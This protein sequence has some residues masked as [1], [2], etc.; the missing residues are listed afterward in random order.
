MYSREESKRVREEFWTE[1]GKQYPRKWLLYNTKIKEVQLKFTFNNDVAQVSIDV[2]S[3]DEVILQY[4]TEK[5]Q[6]LENVLKEGYLSKSRLE[7]N[8]VLPE[9]KAVTRIYV[10]KDNVNIHNRNHWP[11]V[12]EFLYTNMDQLESFFQD[13]RDYISD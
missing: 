10:Q 9:G 13:F 2:S 3:P 1:F 4:Y 5:F 12:S 8:Y 11:E 7:E 6:S